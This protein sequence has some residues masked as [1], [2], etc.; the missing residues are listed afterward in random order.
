MSILFLQEGVYLYTSRNFCLDFQKYT[1]R[2]TSTE[3]N[4]VHTQL[5]IQV[6]LQPLSQRNLLTI[7]ESRGLGKTRFV[8]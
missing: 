5:Y 2:H 4:I 6:Y 1:Q 7:Y 8:Q 3:L